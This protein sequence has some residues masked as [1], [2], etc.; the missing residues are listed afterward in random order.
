MKRLILIALIFSGLNFIIIT[1]GQFTKADI[2][3]RGGEIASVDTDFTFHEAVALKGDKIIFVGKNEQVKNW[4]GP[5][6][7]VIELQG[8]LVIPGMVDA[9]GHPFNLGNTEQEEWFSVGGTKNW[10]EVVVRVAARVKIL[11]PGEWIIGG[12]WYQDDWK[13]NT[14]PVHDELS[15]VSTD[16]PVFLYR[17]GGNSCFVNKKA[18]DVAGIDEN[19]PDPYGGIIHRKPDGKPTGFLVN[20]ANNMVKKH[21]PKSDK[22]IEWYEET[23]KRAARM[24]NEVGLTGWHDAGI[25][26]IYIQAYKNLVDREELTIRV[27]AMLQNPREGNLEQYFEKHKIINY[28]GHHMLQVR[29]VKVFFDG[30]LGSRGAALFHPYTDDPENRGIFEIPPEHLL[31]VSEAALRTGMQVCP[32]AI[33]PRANSVYLDM[34]DKALQKY[35]VKNH[36]FR[37]EH[38]EIIRPEDIPRFS[39]LG[40]IPSVQPIHHTEDMVFLKDRLGKERCRQMA[41]PWQTFIQAGCVLP[42]GSDFAIYSHNPLTGFYAAITRQD[43]AGHPEEG[44]YADQCMTREEALRGYTIWPAYAAFLEDKVGSIEKGKL[45]DL[46]VLDKN[47]L[48]IEPKEILTTKVLYTIVAGVIVYQKQNI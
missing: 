23:Y 14:I 5:N 34:V 11:R 41:S 43:P 30:A 48:K 29:S 22:P 21:F 42:C 15:A 25:D 47:I 36:R 38:A 12:G 13:D 32:H 19:T 16:N 6:T 18:L 17:R 37:S 10:Q 20:M 2:V 3:L 45:A 46:V 28:D 24:C 44:W 31:E 33:G 4:I 7:R 26:P 8:K 40:I 9:H 1:C 27:N 39:E 35:P